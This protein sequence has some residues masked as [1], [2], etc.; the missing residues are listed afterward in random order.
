MSKGGVTGEAAI[1][2][3][4]RLAGNRATAQ[5]LAAHVQR[6]ID[7][8]LPPKKRD[9]PKLGEV[10]TALETYN[11]LDDTDYQDRFNSLSVL[12]RKIH[13]WFAAHPS[14][15][16][17][18]RMH[19]SLQEL[20]DK[21]DGEHIALV[22]ATKADKSILPLDTTHLSAEEIM[23]LKK[24][25]R[26]L[27][28]QKGNIEITGKDKFKTKMLAS[29]GKM[30]GTPT[31][32]SILQFLNQKKAGL[33]AEEAEQ[34]SI[35]IVEELPD[36]YDE[37]KGPASESSYV[38]SKVALEEE[39]E[40]AK[41]KAGG[42]AWAGPRSKAN[43]LSETAAR[44]FKSATGAEGLTKAILAGR[45]GVRMGGKNYEFGAGSGSYVVMNE[46][47]GGD[48]DL[49]LSTTSGTAALKRRFLTLGHELGHSFKMLAG[50]KAK[51]FHTDLFAHLEPDQQKRGFWT[52]PEELINI[53]G[54]ENKMRQ[55]SGIE[56]RQYHK[57]LETIK[58]R[59]RNDKLTNL[60][61]TLKAIDQSADGTPSYLRADAMRKEKVAQFADDDVYRE[62]KER[63]QRI[64]DDFD[65]QE[66]VEKKMQDLT[67]L[68]RW[69]EQRM[70][71]LDSKERKEFKKTAAYK[72]YAKQ[73]K[74]SSIKKY[75]QVG[76]N[77]RAALEADAAFWRLIPKK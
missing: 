46:A 67:D 27:V 15:D 50:A 41:A 62:V 8:Q 61:G 26:S 32:V 55:E 59:R 29:L 20:L 73:F 77:H 72:E 53:T 6:Q 57:P 70:K 22:G 49:H 68:K 21:S 63:I 43:V 52:N 71:A 38:L 39:L 11:A 31:G 51:E 14:Q 69:I 3:L 66:I 30:L 54:I 2:E 48:A 1:I 35:T 37:V 34:R 28:E 12:E 25:W 45:K 9:T 13:A 24:L 42:D 36:E 58:A 10:R 60:I 76:V 75:A 17:S 4:Q 33:S 40:K 47:V 23:T 16:F 7:H 65:P 44:K 5:L 18:E 64:V 19:R 56:E 74:K